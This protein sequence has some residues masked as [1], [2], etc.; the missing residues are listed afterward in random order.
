M[1]ESSIEGRATDSAAAHAAE[2]ARQYLASDG[3]QVDHPAAGNLILLYTKGRSSGEIRR[4]PVRFFEVGDD[5]LVAA[6]YRGSPHHPDW[7]LNLVADRRVWVRR[8]AR[9]YP[10][11]AVTIDGA[12][13]DRLWES[14]VVPRAPQFADYQA[15]TVRVIPLV[16][17][18]EAS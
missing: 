12:E 7:Y 18:I 13:R 6:S 11:T 16:R 10:A 14:V 9:F 4:T 5:L 3:A 8:D 2:H 15:S 1:T 17:L